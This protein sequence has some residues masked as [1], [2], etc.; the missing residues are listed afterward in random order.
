MAKSK[1][2]KQQTAGTSTARVSVKPQPSQKGPDSKAVRSKRRSTDTRRTATTSQDRP[3]K[4]KEARERPRNRP[5]PEQT[6]TAAEIAGRQ[7]LRVKN[8]E[9]AA[10]VEKQKVKGSSVEVVALPGKVDPTE[11]KPGKRDTLIKDQL[12]AEGKA[13]LADAPRRRDAG[14][15]WEQESVKLS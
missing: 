5:A 1:T 3:P 8:P 13:H 10:P 2:K 4:G 9:V 11:L 15:E 6:P 14:G 12:R 7:P